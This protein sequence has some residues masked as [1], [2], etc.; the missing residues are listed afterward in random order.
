MFKHLLVGAAT[1]S[2]VFLAACGGGGSSGSS[3]LPP[4]G[5]SGADVTARAT[6]PL[7]SVQDQ[8]ST[9]VFGPLSGAVAGTPLEG[10]V[11]CANELVTY[12]ILDVVDLLAGSL[13]RAANPQD[14]SRLPLASEALVARVRAVAFDL[15]QLLLGL[16]NQGSGCLTA[17][18]SVTGNSQALGMLTGGGNPLAGTPLSPLG[19][20][21]APAL[22]NFLIA[23]GGATPATDLQLSTVSDLYSQLNTALQTALA[24]I[25]DAALEAPVA[26]GALLT[27]AGALQDLD[28]LLFAVT[29]YQT[30]ATEVALES[31]IGNTVDNLLTRVIPLRLIED[32]AG[33][34]GVISAPII[35]ATD[36]LATRLSAVVAQALD[37]LNST[38]LNGLLSPI[39]DPIENTVLPTLLGPIID[40]ISGG[41]P[42]G[43]GSGGLPNTPLTPVVDLVQG[44]LGGLLGGLG[45]G[46]GGGGGDCA[47]ANIPLLGIL[48]PN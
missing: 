18:N 21:L 8:I 2:T 13:Q 33:Q 30:G 34:P 43:T 16:A 20:I 1:A 5:G 41:L 4:G 17:G 27:V 26:G 48:C 36:Q 9:G 6:G 45:G 19:S 35:A 28:S 42:T 39:L 31:L 25:P 23:T 44:V 24:Q 32:Q 11:T 3:A 46:G 47:L 14:L 7:D 29:R 37:P 38:V 22:G 40:A 15:T 12:E 10:V